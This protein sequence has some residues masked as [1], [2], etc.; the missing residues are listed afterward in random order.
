M[1]FPSFSTGHVIIICQSMLLVVALL[2]IWIWKID[3]EGQKMDYGNGNIAQAA[4]VA[5]IIP[6]FPPPPIAAPSPAVKTHEDKI[7]KIEDDAGM[8]LSRV[9]RI[10]IK[11]EGVRAR[12]YLD[13]DSQV[14]IG[15]GRNLTGNGVSIDELHAIVDPV[16]YRHI[17]SHASVKGGRVYIHSLEAAARVFPQPLT[18]YDITMLLTDDL[19]NVRKEAEQVFGTSWEGIDLVRREVIVDLLYNLGLTRFRQFKK[20]IAA[21]KASKWHESAT[22]LLLSE[23]ARQ[24]ITRYHRDATVLQTGDERYF[25]IQ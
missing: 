14:T 22:E 12:P 5:G 10:I 21:V 25:G 6:D 18:K 23:A 24:N 16:D 17:L 1:R 4:R 8:F 19:N 2:W 13:G 15:I 3:G 7:K 20:F 9:A 11:D